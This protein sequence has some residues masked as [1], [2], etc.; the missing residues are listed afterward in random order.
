VE[1]LK[2]VPPPPVSTPVPE[3]EPAWTRSD[4]ALSRWQ[5]EFSPATLKATMDEASKNIEE[6]IIRELRLIQGVPV[7]GAASAHSDRSRKSLGGKL[8]QRQPQ[9]LSDLGAGCPTEIDA[10]VRD[11][12]KALS[13][14]KVVSKK[15]RARRKEAAQRALGTGGIGAGKSAAPSAGGSACGPVKAPPAK[16]GGSGSVVHSSNEHS[17]NGHEIFYTEY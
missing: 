2:Q 13:W 14:A 1:R 17:A 10:E 8:K 5:N 12:T 9:P 4:E 15:A 16:S 6:R 11:A 7:Q 3:L